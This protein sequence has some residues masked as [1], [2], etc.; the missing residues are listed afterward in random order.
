MLNFFSKIIHRFVGLRVTGGWYRGETMKGV[1]NGKGVIR[2]TS[3]T[4]YSGAFRNGLKHG[5]GKIIY[6]NKFVYCGDWLRG[7]AIG[8]GQVTYK[9]GDIYDGRVNNFLR[10][11]QGVLSLKAANVKIDA[12]WKNDLPAG[13][14]IVYAAS[15]IFRGSFIK[16]IDDISRSFLAVASEQDILNYLKINATG[17]IDF[18]DGL[19]ISGTWSDFESAQNITMTDPDGIVW[20]WDI[21]KNKL[22]GLARAMLPSGEVYDCFWADGIQVRAFGGSIND[23]KP[24]FFLN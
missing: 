8:H 24:N 11:G 13:E 12:E 19:K 16:S 20:S 6:Q 5:D 15:F 9:N 7:R 2:Y 1:P 18:K 4:I 17:E 21:K 23:R 14:M 10:S 3:G 22:D